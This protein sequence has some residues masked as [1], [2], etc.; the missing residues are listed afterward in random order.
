MSSTAS[1]SNAFRA[2][3]QGLRAVAVTLVLLY[4]LWPAL[5][6]GGYVGVDVFFVISGYLITGMLVREAERT[7]RVSLA[8]FYARRIARLLPAAT[9]TLLV[10]GIVSFAILPRL[11]WQNTATEVTASTFYLENWLLIVKS[12]DYLA[13][14]STASPVQHFWSLSVEEQFYIVWPFV[15]LAALWLSRR[16]GWPRRRVLW[17]ALLALALASLAC[18]VIGTARTPTP[19]YFSSVTRFWELALGGLLYLWQPTPRATCSR[20][21]RL[22]WPGLLAIAASAAWYSDLTAF[23]GHAALLPTLGAAA[24]IHGGA[25]AAPGYNSSVLRSRPLV[26]L[27][28]IS[29]SLYLWHW[30]IIVLYHVGNDAGIG[31][32]QGI[33]ILALSIVVAHFSKRF[34]ED[35]IRESR[36]LRNHAWRS[37]ALGAG[38]ALACTALATTLYARGTPSALDIEA[39]PRTDYPGALALAPGFVLKPAPFRPTPLGAARDRGRVYGGHGTKRCIQDAEVTAAMECEYGP[40]DAA[41]TV[42]LVG[43]SLAAH[44]DPAFE[45]LAE[46]RGWRVLEYMKHSCAFADVTVYYSGFGRDFTECDEW[47]QAVLRR[48]LL[49]RPD[50]V[51][52][53]QS[54]G[55]RLTGRDIS[56]SIPVIAQG[57][58]RTW[59]ELSRAGIE[60]AVMRHTPVQSRSVLECLSSA[61]ASIEKCSATRERALVGG[62]MDVAARDNP[63]VRLIDMTDQFCSAPLCPVVIGNVLVY[64]DGH[65]LTATYARTL[66][67]MLEARLAEQIPLLRRKPFSSAARIPQD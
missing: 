11:R 48:L 62:P 1:P 34:I 28:G 32:R 27:G 66:A 37:F 3:I 13:S 21:D 10:V 12:V 36:P 14:A 24:V 49:I 43:D 61:D 56:A 51:V 57:L 44:W 46:T 45:L 18:S 52:V 50:V 42:A 8:R 5:V 65:H 17:T 9:A 2:D 40:R 67:P 20:Q 33:A 26:Y 64:S 19:A 63:E 7:D 22:V 30:P 15:I 54:A 25:S 53:S 55:H 60:I 16:S 59:H 39:L 58:R 29:Y 41:V 35:P 23:P 38:T 4:H 31:V 47:N 6:P